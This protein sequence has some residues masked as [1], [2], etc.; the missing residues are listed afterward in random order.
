MFSSDIWSTQIYGKISPWIDLDAG[1]TKER[2]NS[3][4][5]WHF[6]SH[7]YFFSLFVYFYFHLMGVDGRE[8]YHI[9]LL[10]IL[11]SAV[12]LSPSYYYYPLD[13]GV[14]TRDCMGYPPFSPWI[15][16]SVSLSWNA[17]LKLCKSRQRIASR[18]ALHEF[19]DR[20]STHGRHPFAHC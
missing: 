4:M 19:V 16:R 10:N 12:L 9:L 3:E 14:Q 17:V 7:G 15:S 6:S 2:R 18:S 11:F 5:V 13:I 8:G 1:N 20:G